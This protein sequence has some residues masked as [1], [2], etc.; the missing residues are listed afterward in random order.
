MPRTGFNTSCVSVISCLSQ[1]VCFQGICDCKR[2]IGSESYWDGTQCKAAKSFGATCTTFGISECKWLEELTVCVNSKCTCQK[3]YGSEYYW[4][5]NQCQPAGTYNQ[6]CNGI[7]QCQA[8][9]Q[10]TTCIAN[11]CDCKNG[12]FDYVLQACKFCDSGW[13]YYDGKC[14]IALIRGALPYSLYS[15]FGTY[16]KN[17]KSP[18]SSLADITSIGLITFLT[19]TLGVTHIYVGSGTGVCGGSIGSC[20]IMDNGCVLDHACNHNDGCICEYTLWINHIIFFGFKAI[21][22]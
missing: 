21:I 10:N 7:N 9:T 19:N 1:F 13:T 5:G 2:V 12:K 6:T 11:T 15:E 14:Y 8:I 4:D 20:P 3:V 22:Y 18:L 17:L 16:C